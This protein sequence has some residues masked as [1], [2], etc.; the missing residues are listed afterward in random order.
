MDILSID[1][2]LSIAF[3]FV[4]SVWALYFKT[5]MSKKAESDVTKED[6]RELTQRV[7]QTKE[8]FNVNLEKVKSNLSLLANQALTVATEKRNVIYEFNDKY[9]EWFNASID[10]ARSDYEKA[11]MEKLVNTLVAKQMS[12]SIATKRME[13]FFDNARFVSLVETITSRTQEMSDLN[14]ECFLACHKLWHAQR[15]NDLIEGAN[16][17]DTSDYDDL[18]E[19][20]KKIID[21]TSDRLRELH[22]RLKP[23]LV[24][25]RKTL[26]SF[27][28]QILEP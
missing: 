8:I 9:F 24:E 19:K 5:Y 28:D 11:S 3:M 2:I 25:M 6:I 27:I 23:E 14:A 4:V 22:D 10:L 21:I 26:R 7:E 17:F 20:Q 18:K 12:F 16:P 1:N 15:M 13:I